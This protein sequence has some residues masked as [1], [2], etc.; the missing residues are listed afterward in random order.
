MFDGILFDLDGTLW[1][2]TVSICEVWNR[3]LSRHGEVKR[4]P[5]TVSEV[6]ATMGLLLPDIARK[7][8][9]GETD[10]T[11]SALLEEHCALETADLSEHGGLL[12]PAVEETLA[13]LGRQSKLFVVSNCQDGYIQCFFAGHGLEHYFSGFECAGHTGL[14]KSGNIALVAREY[15]LERPVYVGDTALDCSSARE[16]GV[17]FL[18]AAYGFGPALPGEQAVASFA[19]IPAALA[20]MCPP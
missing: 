9:P 17:P 2:A 10:A 7:I 3:V 20:A 14:P 5:V 4:P 18:H 13:A 15:G 19:E 12:Y 1:D 6:R 16:A 8:L 11:R